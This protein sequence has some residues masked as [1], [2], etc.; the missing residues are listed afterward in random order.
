MTRQTKGR[1]Q[2][3]SPVKIEMCEIITNRVTCFFFFGT[4]KTRERDIFLDSLP[5][6]LRRLTNAIDLV[7]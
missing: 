1:R 7:N 3:L 4:Q 6:S 5:Y 2:S